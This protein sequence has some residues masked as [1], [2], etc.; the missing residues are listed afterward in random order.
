M[1]DILGPAP[2][3][4]RVARLVDRLPPDLQEVFQER[5]AI[6]EHD[7][8]H[9]RLTGEVQALLDVLDSLVHRPLAL[10]G[11]QALEVSLPGH[12]GWVLTTAVERLHEQVGELGGVVITRQALF[13]LLDRRYGGL[14]WLRAWP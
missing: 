8:G 6:R 5:A 3:D 7:G 13:D 11:V 4:L 2:L 12:R 1:D 10:A 14:A 9:E